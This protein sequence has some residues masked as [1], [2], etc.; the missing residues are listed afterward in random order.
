MQSCYRDEF[1]FLQAP[2]IVQAIFHD[3]YES[4]LTVRHSVL[5]ITGARGTKPEVACHTAHQLLHLL[6][7]LLPGS[8]ISRYLASCG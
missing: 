5:R 3:I 8:V 6:L 4:L 2:L 1:R 7:V